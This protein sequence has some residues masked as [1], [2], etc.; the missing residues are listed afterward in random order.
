MA[1]KKLADIVTV[2][3]FHD[4]YPFEKRLSTMKVCDVMK[5]VGAA[6]MSGRDFDLNSLDPFSEPHS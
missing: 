6:I 1:A 4:I 5:T 3:E 2:V